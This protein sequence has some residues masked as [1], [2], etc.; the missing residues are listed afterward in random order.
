[1]L[2]YRL[3]AVPPILWGTL[4]RDAALI[5]AALLGVYRIRGCDCGKAMVHPT[6][7]LTEGLS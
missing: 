7:I 5:G 1:M 2:S 3:V 4:G 6:S